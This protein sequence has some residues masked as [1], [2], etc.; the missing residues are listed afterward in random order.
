[1]NILFFD[2]ET[3]GLVDFALPKDHPQQP[4]IVQIAAVLFDTETQKPMYVLSL[5]VNPGPNVTM[6]DGAFKAHGLTL[7]YVQTWGVA[8]SYALHIF[9]TLW[10]LSEEHWAYNASY[11]SA[12]IM[13]E[14]LRL[15]RPDDVSLLCEAKDLMKPLTNICKLP[16]KYPGKFKWPKLEEAYRHFLGTEMPNAHDALCDVHATIKVYMAWQETVKSEPE[17]LD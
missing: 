6:S 11:D 12:V 17:S 10:R 9:M 5:L 14:L 2:T 4:H 15:K 3:T 7:E 13:G 16:G 1:M 8:T